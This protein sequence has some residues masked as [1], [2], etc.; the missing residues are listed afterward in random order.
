MT[1]PERDGGRI[2]RRHLIRSGAAATLLAASSLAARA[3]PVRQ[4][5]LRLAAPGVGEGLSGDLFGRLVAPGS[6]F[7]CLTE[8]GPDG[9]LQGELAEAWEPRDGAR[10]WSVTL[11]EGVAFHDGRRFGAEDAVASLRYHAGRA[12]DG[13]GIAS[14]RKAGP[15]QVLIALHAPD[16]GFP[17]L[18]S[19]PALVMLPAGG[20]GQSIAEGTGTG[21]Y[22]L[23]G[24]PTATGVRLRR[25][26]SHYKDGRAGW[27]EAVELL[28]I[29]DPEARSA[30]LLA[31][32]V[33]AAAAPDPQALKGAGRRT[34]PV[35]VSV[36]GGSHLRLAARGADAPA[37]A[38]ALKAGLD[39]DGLVGRFLDGA[40]R[41][42]ADHPL[43]PDG[44][45]E[46]DPARARH[47]LA[48]A[49]V[50]RATIGFGPGLAWMP[51][52]DGLVR[53]LRE[54]A[55][56]AG[57]TLA[58]AD[59]P[60]ILVTLAPAQPT[61]D[62]ALR[63]FPRS[64][65]SDPGLFEARLAASRAARDSAL[66]HEI[67]AELARVLAGEGHTA[68]PVF[69]HARFAHSARLTHL[70]HIGALDMLDSGRIAE[71][72]YYGSYG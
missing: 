52:L 13:L 11:R 20:P 71:R 4:G 26:G 15:H 48:R 41:A 50:D 56:S 45:P 34:G 30:A 2:S 12:A 5:T 8:I 61:D 46:A 49:G 53:T 21:L 60:E 24:P 69:A 28:R 37:L 9:R 18:L 66:R 35:V 25:V 70:R 31:G 6:V 36:A 19:D 27:F 10:S 23:D 54:F 42:A 59:R 38:A 55:G 57:L 16:P 63:R 7:D 43:A 40:G 65:L 1:L 22:R 51:G 3:E 29:A 33:D 68:V 72:W 67:H 39:R 44:V 58:V 47:I 14:V 62:L 32:R 64:G 17:F